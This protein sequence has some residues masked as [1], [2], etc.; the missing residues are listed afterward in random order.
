MTYINEY[1]SPNDDF[2]EWVKPEWHNSLVGCMS[3]QLKCPKNATFINKQIELA[4][5]TEEETK[6]IL[7]KVPLK[8]LPEDTL[9]KLDNIAMTSNYS[10]LSRN[11]GILLTDT[12]KI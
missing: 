10:I 6:M 12:Y 1:S 4:A 8:S 3:C 2:P 9:K 7:D 11:I 5:F